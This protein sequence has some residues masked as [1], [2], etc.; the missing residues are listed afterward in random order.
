MI[1]AKNFQFSPAATDL[2]LGDVL[3]SQLEQQSEAA[4]Q[5]ALKGQGASDAQLSMSPATQ[6]L[7]GFLGGGVGAADFTKM[8]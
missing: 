1:S 8:K 5:A 2:G 6:Q 3:K 4:R 7:F